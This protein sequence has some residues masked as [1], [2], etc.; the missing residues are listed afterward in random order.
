[1]ENN[2]KIETINTI[3]VRDE[4]VY[5]IPSDKKAKIL[6]AYKNLTSKITSKVKDKSM[7]CF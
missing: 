7:R 2:H 1:M 5:K 4:G 6:N 3:L